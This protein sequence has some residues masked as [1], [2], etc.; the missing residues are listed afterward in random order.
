[1]R[2]KAVQILLFTFTPIQLNKAEVDKIKFIR[3]FEESIDSETI[4]YIVYITFSDLLC[5][6][7]NTTA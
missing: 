4:T 2:N 1:M 3:L 7:V 5:L 6:T